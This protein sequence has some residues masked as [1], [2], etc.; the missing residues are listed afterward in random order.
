MT[1]DEILAAID[2]QQARLDQAVTL[3]EAAT[4]MKAA[5]EANIE[6][7]T[8]QRADAQA[9]IVR[10]LEQLANLPLEGD[11]RRFGCRRTS[12]LAAWEARI[13]A[14]CAVAQTFGNARPF[15]H[16]DV[17]ARPDRGRWLMQITYPAP[18]NIVRGKNATLTA[19][20]SQ[21][22]MLR[23]IGGGQR[24][25][26][27]RRGLRAMRPVL[28]PGDAV[29]IN[30]ERYVNWFWYGSAVDPNQYIT[31]AQADQL[32]TE[33]ADA[34][35][36]ADERF[37]ALAAEELGDLYGE[38]VWDICAAG[39]F[40][41][42]RRQDLCRREWPRNVPAGTK[43]NLGSDAYVQARGD[44]ARLVRNLTAVDLMAG[45]LPNVVSISIDEW[46]P[47]NGL[48]DTAAELDAMADEKR[49][50]VAETIRWM[51]AEHPVPVAWVCLYET[52]RPNG[53]PDS[54]VLFAD[55]DQSNDANPDRVIVLAG[56]ASATFVAANGERVPSNDPEMAAEFLRLIA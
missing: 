22:D 45:E 8:N 56:R 25:V 51:R 49:E 18:G 23:A 29:R 20:R 54:T 24:D 36:A 38:I 41:D 46:G 1:R 21:R 39:N 26:E 32:S 33:I 5:A 3:I 27:L 15:T 47:H 4:A 13:G 52:V 12:D 53:R 7:G 6:T 31:R 2:A 48:D 44:V 10:L 17:S 16:G 42:V 19:V 30:N 55:R 14:D 11:W 40:G 50:F 28:Q 37:L 35:R 9:E 43:L 34:H